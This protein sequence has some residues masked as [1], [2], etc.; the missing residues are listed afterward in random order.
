M[1]RRNQPLGNHQH[2]GGIFSHGNRWSSK[3]IIE[4]KEKA[5]GETHQ[6]KNPAKMNTFLPK[7]L[8]GQRK[9]VSGSRVSN[10]R[11]RSN[12]I[13]IEP[14]LLALARSL[15]TLER[16]V[17]AKPRN[18]WSEGTELVEEVNRW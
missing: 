11:K 2:T 5:V 13:R 8:G 16:G 14:C 18:Q 1:L 4:C 7:I 15:V 9:K 10:T 12:D 6:G 3:R 17:S